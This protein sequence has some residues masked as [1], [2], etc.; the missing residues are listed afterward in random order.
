MTVMK[1][2]NVFILQ[3]FFCRLYKMVDS[4]DQ[5]IYTGLMFGVVPFTGWKRDYVYVREAWRK[6]K[7]KF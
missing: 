5:V 7:A 3:L 6:L 1:F 4:E 2:L